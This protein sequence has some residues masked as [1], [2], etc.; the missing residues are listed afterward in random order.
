M[1]GSSAAMYGDG[2]R[3]DV[4]SEAKRRKLAAWIELETKSG[5]AQQ[6][7]HLAS[8]GSVGS[9]HRPTEAHQPKYLRCFAGGQGLRSVT[10]ISKA[11][12]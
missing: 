4:R 9:Y 11:D 1:A 10:R 5:G 7:P 12:R 2:I 3:S 8:G 6:G